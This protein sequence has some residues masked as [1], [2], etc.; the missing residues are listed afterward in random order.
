MEKSTTNTKVDDATNEPKHYYLALGI[1]FGLILALSIVLAFSLFTAITEFQNP[2]FH[3]MSTSS[4][5]PS[6]SV[7]RN[8]R[9]GDIGHNPDSWNLSFTVN[10][11]NNNYIIFYDDLEAKITHNDDVY[12]QANVSTNFYQEEKTQTLIDATFGALSDTNS[13]SIVDYVVHDLH[14]GRPTK[15]SVSLSGKVQMSHREAHNDLNCGKLLVSCEG[16]EVDFLPNDNIGTATTEFQNP[17]F[18]LL[19]TSSPSPSVSVTSNF[20]DGIISHNPDSW[21]LNFMVKNP[22]NNYIIFYNDL[23]AKITYNDNVYWQSNVSA[24]LYQKEKTQTMIDATFGALNDTN[25]DYVVDYVVHDVHVGRPTKFSVS[26][27]GKVQ[28]S[29]RDAHYRLNCGKLH[30]SCE[31]LGVKFIPNVN[32]GTLAVTPNVCDVLLRPAVCSLSL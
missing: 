23:E 22:N 4:P 14:A 5:S 25:I 19:S 31:G 30:I 2:K 3:L 9:Y 32:I 21:N 1:L 11:L 26:L 8:F 10:N 29:H 20:R 7:T 6:F 28:I 17:K 27:S 13:D 15:F 24:S 16:L 18:H 12:W